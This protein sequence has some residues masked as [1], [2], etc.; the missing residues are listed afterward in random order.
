[1]SELVFVP[2]FAVF[3]I[4]ALLIVYNSIT[5]V[6]KYKLNTDK[7]S[8]DLRII[9]LS[10]FH[11]KRC[12][13]GGRYLFDRIAALKPDIIVVAGDSVDRRRPDF[14]RARRFIASVSL[15]AP[16]YVVSGNHECAL[17]ADVFEKLDCKKQLVDNEYK[18]FSDYS[19]LGL[20]DTQDENEIEKQRDI[21]GIFERLDNF[22]IVIVHRPAPFHKGMFLKNRDVDLV[23]C[24]H[25]HGGAVRMP[26]F[27]AVYS[28]D[29]GFFPKYSK[30]IYK[31]NGKVL[32]VSG[33]LGNT[34]IPA[35][36]N[37]FPE[38]VVVDAVGTKK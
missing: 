36:I 26:F 18:I 16:T 30:G 1:M 32:V 27:G 33:G 7:L 11:N 12:F 3:V 23:L 19:V 4:A 35:R 14:E 15:L 37:N 24:G 28:P 13:N 34:L 38:I 9:L 20:A 2:L 25:T 31:E 21:I 5:V 17:G 6:K 22:K 29:D 10:D 8:K